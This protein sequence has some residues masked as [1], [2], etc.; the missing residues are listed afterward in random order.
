[1]ASLASSPSRQCSPPARPA[2]RWLHGCLAESQLKAFI[3]RIVGPL[4]ASALDEYLEPGGS[5]ARRQGPR[6]RGGRTLCRHSRQDPQNAKGMA[7]L[8][9]SSSRRA[10]SSRRA[11]CLIIPRPKRSRKMLISPAARAALELAEQAPLSGAP[12][13]SNGQSRPTRSI[14]RRGSNLAVALSAA[15][16]REA[17]V[18]HL[19]EIIRRD[20][21]WNEMAR[22]SSCFSSSRPGTDG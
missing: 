14:I 20:R 4:G 3:E 11:A 1:M 6:W 8:A 21:Q 10:I 7:G 17:A 22:A 18:D 16:K 19:I 2:G 9:A 13:I 15:G 5:P 12:P